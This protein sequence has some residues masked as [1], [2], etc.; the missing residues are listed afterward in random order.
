MVIH[1]SALALRV[2]V[3]LAFYKDLSMCWT[4]VDLEDKPGVRD[5]C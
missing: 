5:S 3:R 2:E 1:L 4:E